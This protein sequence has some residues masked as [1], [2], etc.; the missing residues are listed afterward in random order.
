[1]RT[2]RQDSGGEHRLAQADD[3]GGP[4]AGIQA[5]DG[6]QALACLVHIQPIVR[7]KIRDR[8]EELA[9]LPQGEI[10]VDQPRQLFAGRLGVT[11]NRP[12]HFLL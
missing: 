3:V 1:M 2:V 4:P 5:A 8:T 10:L 6:A 7:V 9:V 11:Q 12:Q